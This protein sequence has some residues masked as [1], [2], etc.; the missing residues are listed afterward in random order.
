MRRIW[1][2]RNNRTELMMLGVLL[3][4]CILMSVISQTFFTKGN[5]L[6][7][8]SQQSTTALMAIGMTMVIITGGIDLSVGTLL[9]FSGMLAAIELQNS[10]NIFKAILIAYGLALVIGLI[11]GYLIGY[12]KLPAFIV[13]LGTQKVCQSMNYVVTDGSS[14]S[15]FPEAFGF[16]GKGKLIGDIP[17]YLVM[18]I[19]LYIIFSLVMTK[20][21]YG[22]FLYAT[23]SNEEAS[24]LS[25]IKTKKVIMITYVISAFMAATAGLVMI[26]R[27]MACD[28]TYGNGA[29]MDVIAA[30]VIGGTFMSGGKGTLWGTA[31]G[32][33]IVGVLRNSLNL[34]GVNTFWQGTAIGVVIILAVLAEQLSH[35]KKG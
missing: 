6:N 5:L 26:S 21:K 3:F 31:I 18:I 11:N 2:L 13:T 22:R 25:G 35:K 7:I 34:L 15:K 28:P 16:I 4:G 8:C 30:V 27:L 33:F 29:E 23:G 17:F 20:V 10:G 1:T 19:I 24:R 9:G 14:A 12:M 32:V